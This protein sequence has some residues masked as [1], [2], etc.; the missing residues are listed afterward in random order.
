MNVSSYV[1]NCRPSLS[2]SV[3]NF[4]TATSIVLC[5]YSASYQMAI[6]QSEREADHGRKGKHPIHACIVC[7][8]TTGVFYI[9][10]SYYYYYCTRRR[11]PADAV[12]L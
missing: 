9:Y 10:Y 3:Q 4:F 7:R 1:A 6:K 11:R 2:S 12:N 8:I 5:V